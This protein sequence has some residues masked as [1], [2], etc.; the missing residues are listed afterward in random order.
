MWPLEGSCVLSIFS[1]RKGCFFGLGHLDVHIDGSSSSKEPASIGSLPW[2][3][4]ESIID[5]M[6]VELVGST[7]V[8]G[9]RIFSSE[10][11]EVFSPHRAK[12]RL[13]F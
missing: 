5:K 13:F 1:I 7:L 9:K 2:S 8:Q 3:D 11:F 4:G 6:P 12:E 10:T